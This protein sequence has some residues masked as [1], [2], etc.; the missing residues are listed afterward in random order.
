MV[1]DMVALKWLRQEHHTQV[2][3]GLH[4]EQDLISKRK[5]IC[6]CEYNPQQY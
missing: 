2:Q 4:S 1:I 5:C 6:Q 3:V